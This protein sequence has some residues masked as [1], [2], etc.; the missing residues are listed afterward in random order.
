MG[1]EFTS[2][3]GTVQ[4]FYGVCDTHFKLGDVIFNA[5]EDESDG[6]RSYLDSIVEENTA[7]LVFPNAPLSKVKIEK[8]DVLSL[9]GYSFTDEADGYL[10]LLIGTGGTDDYYP[11]FVFE[12]H[13]KLP[14]EGEA[15]CK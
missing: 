12:Y 2:L 7:G 15:Q 3:I 14:P 5:I 1:T 9:D 13:P 4:D 8:Y 11:Y 6:Y 10:W